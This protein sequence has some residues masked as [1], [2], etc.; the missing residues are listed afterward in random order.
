MTTASRI[1]PFPSFMIFFFLLHQKVEGSPGMCGCCQLFSS[2]GS[3]HS[4]LSRTVKTGPFLIT[5]IS[6]PCDLHPSTFFPMLKRMKV[7]WPQGHWW[8]GTQSVIPEISPRISGK[9]SHRT[10]QLNN[11][12]YIYIHQ[13]AGHLDYMSVFIRIK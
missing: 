4:S 1:L 5:S 13:L 6:P 8:R 3:F 2:H 7:I 12:P 11:A 10:E 9:A